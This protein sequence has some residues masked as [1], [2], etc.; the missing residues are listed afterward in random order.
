VA[1]LGYPLIAIAVG[2]IAY[3]MHLSYTS[4]GGTDFV[5]TVYDAAFYPPV[6][7]AGGL[8]FILPS[9]EVNWSI[10]TFVGIWIGLA[11]LVGVAIKLLEV[12]GDKPL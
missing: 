1:W 11:V 3:R 6:M 9:F 4:A 10:W 7:V 5:M 8:Y 2:W 12:L